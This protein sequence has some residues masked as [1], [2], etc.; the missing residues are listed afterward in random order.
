MLAIKDSQGKRSTSLA[1]PQRRD[2]PPP[3]QRDRHDFFEDPF[4]NFGAPAVFSENP[5]ASMSRMME[6]M[7][8][9]AF[10]MFR[11]MD[12]HM[13]SLMRM[14]DTGSLFEDMG[15]MMRGSGSPQFYSQ[16]IVQ[17]T[18][19]DSQGRPIVERYQNQAYGGT[20]QHGTKYGER[21]QAYKN[22]GTGLE[23]YGHERKIGDRSRKVIQERV[24]NEERISDLYRNMNEND[25]SDFDRDWEARARNLGLGSNAL[26]A[27][28]GNIYGR[29]QI[30]D[31]RNRDTV[32]EERRGDYIPDDWRRDNQ[33]VRYRNSDIQP[34]I[35]VQRALPAPQPAQQPAPPRRN[36]PV[37]RQNQQARKAPAPGA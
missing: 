17:S 29:R 21:K 23:K 16:T 2:Y 15:G 5:F 20:D 18:K 34:T 9:Q 3:A 32:D 33:P 11:E 19:Y 30:R 31:N 10:S 25:A 26:P 37:R 35:P 7:H 27:P 28:S 4:S 1:H 36:Q 13:G 8:N 6:D 24:G 14:P 12:R 22:T